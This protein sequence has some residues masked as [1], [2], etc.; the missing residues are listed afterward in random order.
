MT[1]TQMVTG[2]EAIFPTYV[3]RGLQLNLDAT[4]PASYPGGGST[5]YDISGNGYNATLYN[6]PTYD[7]ANTSVG[8]GSFNFDGSTQY[9][10]TGNVTPSFA[11]NS[12]TTIEVWAKNTG[13]GGCLLGFISTP[14]YT[15]P[16]YHNTLMEF[17]TVGPFF[18]ARCCIYVQGVGL[19]YTSMGSQNPPL[20]Q[21][22]Q[23]VYT[24]TPN[25]LKGLA[26]PN[27]PTQFGVPTVSNPVTAA[28][29]SYTPVYWQIGHAESTNTAAGGSG[30]YLNG[31]VGIVRAYNRVLTTTEIAQNYQATRAYYGL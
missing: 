19:S 11:T 5:W 3:T 12:A 28:G 6:N 13:T 20:N 2:S 4:N 15:A 1:T 21:W 9:A 7:N 24:F 18:T 30:N 14:N 25:T 31:R 16:A 29:S 8:L 22:N 10:V 17:C 27:P 26:G 23:Y